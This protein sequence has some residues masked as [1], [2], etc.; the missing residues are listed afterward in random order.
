MSSGEDFGT[1]LGPVGTAAGQR[2]L[3]QS[4]VELART[5]FGAKACSIMRFDHETDELVFEA[6]AGEGAGT[7]VGRRIP[8]RTGIAGW[9]L[10]SEEPIAI[11]D[12]R[13]DPRFARDVAEDTG[14]VPEQ[15]AV[16]P[17]LHEERSLGV[18]NVLDQ[19]ASAQLGLADMAVLGR[20]A[21]HAAMALAVVEATRRGQALHAEGGAA[22]ARIARALDSAEG[23]RRDAATALL[24]ALETLLRPPL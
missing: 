17:L 8:S 21:A 14:Y 11:A 10:A 18:L 2:E 7:L 22:L 9:C 23:S 12:V 15:L 19:G 6:V 16:Y 13:Q 20:F 4:I 24:G 5:V 1:S 3:L